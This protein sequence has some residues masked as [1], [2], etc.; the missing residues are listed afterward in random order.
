MCDNLGLRIKDTSKY[1]KSFSANQ[2]REIFEKFD[3][4]CA[5][6]GKKI[7]MD[8]KLSLTS[9]SVDHVIPVDYFFADVDKKFIND[10]ANLFPSCRRCNQYKTI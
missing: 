5:Y 8:R 1:R 10:F 6:C 2:K 3:G 4:R 7:N 9:L